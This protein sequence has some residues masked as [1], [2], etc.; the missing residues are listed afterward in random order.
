MGTIPKTQPSSKA[1]GTE[2]APE[3]YSLTKITICYKSNSFHRAFIHGTVTSV[4]NIL[5]LSFRS[6]SNQEL[7]REG[8][9]DKLSP[10]R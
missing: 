8:S 5:G 9:R 10:E 2:L 1:L 4:K 7:H 6:L 3:T